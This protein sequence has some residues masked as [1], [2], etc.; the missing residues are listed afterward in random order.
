MPAKALKHPPRTVIPH[1]KNPNHLLGPQNLS[2]SSKSRDNLTAKE[3]R[4]EEALDELDKQLDYEDIHGPG[5]SQYEGAWWR[6]NPGNSPKLDSILQ[7]KG[8]RDSLEDRDSLLDDRK[9]QVMEEVQRDLDFTA[10]SL[11]FADLASESSESEEEAP[12]YFSPLVDIRH[13]GSAKESEK[14][15][16]ESREIKDD[17]KRLGF[18]ASTASQLKK[19]A[20]REAKAKERREGKD[21]LIQEVIDEWS[22]RMD[23]LD[24][25]KEALGNFFNSESE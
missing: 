3:L 10:R 17:R 5:T 1:G 8:V 6:F 4:W 11:K 23:I 22:R 20:R 19:D 15:L 16:G 13:K 14:K 7:S 24:G 2:Y 9:K 21:K 18:V 25:V 12:T